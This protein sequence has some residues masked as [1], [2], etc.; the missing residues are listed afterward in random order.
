MNH[1]IIG[2]AG[3]SGSGKTTLA[4]RLKERFGEN[5]VRLI[6]HDS[7]YKRHDDLPFEERCKLNYDHPDAFDND[8]LIEHL[9]ALRAGQAIDCPIYDYADHNRSDR[10]LHIEPAPVLI[11]EGILPFVEPALCALFDY[12]IYVDTDADERILRRILRDVKERG[13]SLDSVILQYRTTVKPMHEAFVEPSKRQ[14]DVIV[15]N[16]GENGPALEMLAH[17]IRSLIQRANTL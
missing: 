17:H 7:Y 14:A 3:G 16:G 15:P 11:V 12:K 10:T 8:L 4:L 5:E 9:K 6:P 13:R 2:I 1:L